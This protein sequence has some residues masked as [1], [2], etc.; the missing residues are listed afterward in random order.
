[1]TIFVDVEAN[2][3]CPESFN[4]RFADDGPAQTVLKV[5]TSRPDDSTYRWWDVI[6]WRLNQPSG[7]A[8]GCWILLE[9]KSS[10]FLIFG[11]NGGLRLKAS[12]GEQEGW[13]L[14][15]PQQW[16]CSHL[17]LDG[18]DNVDFGTLM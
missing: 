18:A 12:G 17:V 13:S 10:A 2:E 15:N 5:K 6:A 8:Q 9:D 11:G 4:K 7:Q 3:N 16:G 1:M 14:K